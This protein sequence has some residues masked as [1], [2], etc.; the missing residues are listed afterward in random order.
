M[1]EMAVTNAG[2]LMVL[3]KLNLLHL[4]RQNYAEIRFPRAVYEE[5]IT[6]GIRYG[7]EDAQILR[8]FLYYNQSEIM[9]IFT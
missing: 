5:C 7:Y 9:Q 2:P 4:L 3:S 1:M 6:N 8:L